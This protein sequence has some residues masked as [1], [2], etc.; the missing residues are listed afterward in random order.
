MDTTLD[1]AMALSVAEATMQD[2]L[3]AVTS[4][5]LAPPSVYSTAPLQPHPVPERARAIRRASQPQPRQL[6]AP[7][8]RVAGARSGYWFA[9]ALTLGIMAI[10]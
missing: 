3:A 7:P 4:I 5:K 1:G 8:S 9:L 6:P 2:W 10:L